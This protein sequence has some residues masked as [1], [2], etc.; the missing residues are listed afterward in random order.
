M[1]LAWISLAALIAR[2]HAE[3]GDERQRR[4]RVAGHGLDR[5]RLPGRHAGREGDRHLPDRSAPQPRWR[6]AALRHG[7][8][9]RHARPHRGA[10]G[11]RLP[12]QRR[13]D[14]DHAVRHRRDAVEHR[15]GQ[16]RDD[17]DHGADGDGGRRPRGDPAVPDGADGR[18]RRAGRRAVAV[19]ADRPHRQHQHGEDRSR[20]GT[21]PSTYL[22]NLLAHVGRD[23]RRLLP[24]RRLEAVH[25]AAR[26]ADRRWRNPIRP[27][28]APE[29]E[30]VDIEPFESAA[31]A[32]ARGSRHAGR[33]GDPV[34]GA[35]RHG[36]ADRRGDCCRCSA[37]PTR[38]T[39]SRR[40]RG[41]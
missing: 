31:L 28:A 9:Q 21:R 16:H 5:R 32:D 7:Q 11:S 37:P 29:E 34:Q 30:I 14:P 17:G 22:N 4:R 20:P 8:Q 36:G 27:A 40:C 19:R 12:R 6:H 1:N 10:G 24:L 33:R 25:A 38:R 39:R 3:H 26:R 18:Q 23:V 13:R 2:H 15:A 41:A 35:R